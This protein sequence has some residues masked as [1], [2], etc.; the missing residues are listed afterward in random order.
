VTNPGAGSEEHLGVLTFEQFVSEVFRELE[1]SD[2]EER[3]ERTLLVDD[4][5]LDSL[6][7]Y[8]FIYVAEQLAGLPPL[9][10]GS[11]GEDPSFNP[12][13]S[14]GDAYTYYLHACVW[15]RRVR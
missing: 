2:V 3:S 4:L 10:E 5:G 7:A 6:K 15:A 13:E 1:M 11:G 9:Q 12:I 14:L 8:E